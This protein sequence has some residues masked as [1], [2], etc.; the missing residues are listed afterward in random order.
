ML[1]IGTSGWQY[2]DWRPSFYE[3]APTGRWLELYANSFGTV[4]TPNDARSR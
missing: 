3:G 2:A 4:E 1:C